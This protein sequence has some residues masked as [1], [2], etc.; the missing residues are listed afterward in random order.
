MR[1]VLLSSSAGAAI[2][3]TANRRRQP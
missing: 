1:R 2:I 3:N